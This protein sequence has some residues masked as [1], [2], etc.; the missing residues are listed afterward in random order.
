MTISIRPVETRDLAAIGR[1]AK[2]TDLFPAEILEDMI[3]GY[4]DGSKADLWFVV[5]DDGIQGFG[6]V[7][8]SGWR[9]RHGTCW[10]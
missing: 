8:L 3:A 5:D 10:Q 4:L 9:T 6:F 2:A 1:L 7:S